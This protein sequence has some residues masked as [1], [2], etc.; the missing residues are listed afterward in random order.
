MV[1]CK[2]CKYFKPGTIG[3]GWCDLKN[4]AA[5][6]KDEACHKRVRRYRQPKPKTTK[7]TLDEVFKQCSSG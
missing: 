7:L 1:L 2:S 5:L 4:K 6:K 3:P